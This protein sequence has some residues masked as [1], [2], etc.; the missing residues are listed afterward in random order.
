MEHYRILGLEKEA[1]QLE[2]KKAYRKMARLYHPDLNPGKNAQERFIR[3]KIAYDT[4]CDPL[5]REDYDSGFSYKKTSHPQQKQK[6][7]AQKKA[8]PAKRKE[9]AFEAA[10]ILRLLVFELG[11]HDY[12]LD[13][14]QVLGIVGSATIKYF[15]GD[16]GAVVGSLNNR[17]EDWFI[18]D[19]ARCFD[20]AASADDKTQKVILTT[21]TDPK[22]GF[23]VGDV[24]LVTNL[25]EE[26]LQEA[27]Q[28]PLRELAYLSKM[29]VVEGRMIFILDLEHILPVQVLAVLKDL[30]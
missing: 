28:S 8:A 10:K 5:K 23:L 19:L 26:N 29:A 16:H 17:G 13:I 15:D 18:V 9:P 20:L 14:D 3:V 30:A 1:S 21:H 12:A 7:R 24:D 11:G 4:L 6:N 22:V 27:T 25:T 2:I